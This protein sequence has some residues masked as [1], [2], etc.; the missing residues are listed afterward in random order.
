MVSRSLLPIV[1]QERPP[2]SSSRNG[3]ITRSYLLIRRRPFRALFLVCVLLLVLVNATTIGTFRRDFIYLIRPLWDTPERPF[4]IIP[5]YPV[6]VT[7]K[8]DW[9]RLHGWTPRAMGTERPTIIDAVPIST[10][11]DM[12]EVRMREYAPFVKIF[13]IVESSMTH[14]GQM[15]PL[16]FARERARFDKIAEE[17]GA[18][19]VYA[20]VED[21][22]KDLPVGSFGNE[23][24]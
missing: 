24:K 9:C 12:L 8:R 22:E 20:E 5:H 7:G 14:A 19:I 18:R 21:M 2:G 10:E 1:Q 16:H 3:P 23:I 15:K 17:G 11:L 13:V 6:P 4:T